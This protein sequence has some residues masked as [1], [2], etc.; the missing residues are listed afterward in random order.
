MTQTTL[1]GCVACGAQNRVSAESAGKTLRC[2]KCGAD[3]QPAGVAPCTQAGFA[4]AVLEA[5]L[6]VLVDFWAP[7][8][9]PC[10][11]LGPE[12]EKLSGQLA[13]RLKVVKVNIDEN[14]ALAAQFN[15]RSV[16]T[17]LMFNRGKVVETLNGAMSAMAITQRLQTHLTA[18]H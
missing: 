10:R 15:I 8:C 1:L 4:A 3:L 13:G 9:A 6:P 5:P 14:P 17:M 12:L 7:W 2:G 18:G 16:P 11:M